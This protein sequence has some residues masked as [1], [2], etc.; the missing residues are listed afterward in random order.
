MTAPQ[1][2]PDVPMDRYLALPALDKTRI[3]TAWT[4]TPAHYKWELD[5]P[6]EVET[7]AMRLGTAVHACIL[8]P[9]LFED[10][11][12]IGGPVNPKTG[13]CYGAETQKYAEWAAEQG[14]P[15]LPTE[16][17]EICWAISGAV[18]K[19]GTARWLLECGAR[20]LSLTWTDVET[21]LELKGRVDAWIEKGGA[22]P[23]LK[24]CRCAAARPFSIDAYRLGYHFQLAMYVDGMKAA[25][26]AETIV[27]LIIAVETSEPYAVA[28]YQFTDEAI[29][30]GRT[31][32][33][34]TLAL[35]QKC[36]KAGDWPGYPDGITE[37]VLPPWAG[38]EVPAE[39][40]FQE[41]LVGA[42]SADVREA[43]DLGD[44]ENPKDSLNLI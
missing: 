1:L 20:E 37:L 43:V 31:Q 12:A 44:N 24:T 26:G 6:S 41:P 7:P 22:L 23:D 3:W 5:H 9:N 28:V 16:N 8:E 4:K 10:R 19:H 13:R 21:G 15:T 42:V 33:K 35:I 29:E 25:T 17:A 32:Y 39:W 34:R 30:I 36:E 27:P 18:R 38:T 11:Y 2:L 40:D 14:K